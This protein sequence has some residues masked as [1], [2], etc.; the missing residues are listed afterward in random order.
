MAAGSQL[1]RGMSAF[2][3]NPNRNRAKIMKRSVGCAVSCVADR[4]ERS[5]DPEKRCPRGKEESERID[6]KGQ[7]DAGE[8]PEENASGR[9]ASQDLWHRGDYKTKHHDAGR[10]RPELP[11][12]GA[13]LSCPRNE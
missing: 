6:S 11:Q 5:Q 1:C 8:N 12:I 3:A 7:F 2:F 9:A 10:N 13:T 4:V